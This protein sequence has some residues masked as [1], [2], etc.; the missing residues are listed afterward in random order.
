M[1]KLSERTKSINPTDRK[2][3]RKTI[4]RTLSLSSY[5][6]EKLQALSYLNAMMPFVNHY[7]KDKD[8]RIAAYKRH[9]ELFN[10]TPSVGSYITGISASMEKR[11]AEDPNFD[12]SVI[13]ATKTSIMGPLASMGDFIFWGALRAISLS[14]GIAFAL[15]GSI[16]GAILHLLIFNIPASFVRYYGGII[17]FTE[18][19]EF[20][21][22]AVNSGV[23][24]FITRAMTILGLI[25]VGALT[26]V[27]VQVP[28]P[29]FVAF[30]NLVSI[31]SFLDGLLPC[32]IPLG[33]VFGS[34]ALNKKG[35]NGLWIMLGMIALCLLLSFFGVI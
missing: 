29:D 35:I 32:L 5:F 14:I 24:N 9:W 6:F 28:V 22:K 7:N 15:Q 27:A 8:K 16:L 34:F 18:G 13:N 26:C 4:Y 23:V 33:L 3:L 17:G 1:T 30:G 19:T 10:T 20:L 12:T 11:A 21:T 2:L 31:Q 25:M